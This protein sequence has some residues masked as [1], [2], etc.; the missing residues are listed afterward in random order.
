MTRL[1][2]ALPSED[3]DG[4]GVRSDDVQESA[5]VLNTIRGIGKVNTEAS[6]A[7]EKTGEDERPT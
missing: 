3:P 1:T 2:T 6:G 7:R 5:E 4:S